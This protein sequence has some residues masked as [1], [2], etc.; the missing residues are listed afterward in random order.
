MAEK[1]PKILH[2]I[3][4]DNYAPFHDP[5]ERYLESWRREMPDYEIMLWNASNLDVTE[6]EWTREAAAQGAPVFLAEYFRWKV[7]REYGGMYLDAD[8]E[9]INGKILSGI[10]DELYSQDRYD[11]F[12][13]I[14]ERSNGFPTAQ[15]VGARKGSKLVEF[16]AELYENRLAP[17]WPWREQ[18]GLIGPQLMAL[19]YLYDGINA[20]SNGFFPNIDSPLIV[21]QTKV[22]PQTYFSPKFT[23]TGTELEYN[24]DKTC[25]YHMFAN[26]NLSFARG[27]KAARIQA[28][29]L[30]FEELRE[31]LKGRGDL[32]CTFTGDDL[33]TRI[34][35]REDG[36]IRSQGSRGALAYGPYI[37]FGEGRYE[38]TLEFEVKSRAVL[39]VEI[40]AESG[41]VPLTSRFVTLDAKEGDETQTVRLGFDVGPRGATMVEVVVKLE[42]LAEIALLSVSFARTEQQVVVK[43]PAPL[44]LHRVYFGFDGKPDVF[45][46]Y[47]KTWSDQ[48]P[49]FEIRHWNATNL[50]LGANE[51]VAKCFE[52]RDHAFLTDYFRWRILRDHGGIYLDADIELVNG[53]NLRM[54][55]LEMNL[56]KDYDAVLGI[57]ERG[58]G[59]YTA[60]S[61]LSKPG[62]DLANFMCRTYDK[63]GSFVNWRKK[64]FYFWAPQV[65]ALYF[66]E[67]KV[68]PDGLGTTPN[69]NEPVV[70]ARVKI[71]PQDWFSPLSPSA[72]PA[73]PFELN[74][75]TANTT[76]CHHFAC[77]WHSADSIYLAHSR[78]KG[79]QAQAL[80][81]DLVGIPTVSRA[82]KM[83]QTALLPLKSEGGT[84]VSFVEQ[85]YRA[86]LGREADAGGAVTFVKDLSDGLPRSNVIA[87]LLKSDEF[88]MRNG[89]DCQE[90]AC[91]WWAREE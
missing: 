83:L 90:E 9:I 34:G 42:S 7:L 20:N 75:L 15:T 5:Y 32:P 77:S 51:F 67:N 4:F 48:L 31:K 10:I 76:L 18:R 23:L 8:C 6:H 53:D 74:A 43:G 82:V 39:D 45:A 36:K 88:R 54:L 79:G 33:E 49:D 73:T 26:S 72:D 70:S 87:S 81:S 41:D 64:G 38:A 52:E 86:V 22:Y 12:F 71:M 25:V 13:G 16:M 68:N 46:R 40:T 85:A 63:F 30:T 3:Y 89:A 11:T 2:R 27:S 44:V 80:L 28:K 35:I 65:T 59:W 19:F 47:L 14:E 78:E 60:H 58:G 1:N 21:K 29:P 66:T 69:I 57:D 56:S 55:L 24:P 62:S 84:D 61:V 50:D 91:E 37:P 17:F